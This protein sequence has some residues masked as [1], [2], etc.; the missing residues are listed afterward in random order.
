MVGDD[1]GSFR[2][3][4]E[5]QPMRKGRFDPPGPGMVEDKDDPTIQR[6]PEGEYVLNEFDEWE[7]A[8]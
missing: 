6:P 1:P 7:R 5:P 8:T 2:P 4:E 3:R